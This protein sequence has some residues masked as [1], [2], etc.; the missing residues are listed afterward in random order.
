MKRRRLG[1]QPDED[2]LAPERRDERSELGHRADDRAPPPWLPAR[3]GERRILAQDRLLELLQR[4]AWL[5]PQLVHQQPPPLAVPV[6]RLRLP[7][8]A[9]EGEHQLGARALP[10]RLLRD[11]PLELGDDACVLAQLQ[12]GVD[13]LLERMQTQLGQPAR[14]RLCERLLVKLGERRAAPELERLA[15]E[16]G[17]PSGLSS[18]SGIRL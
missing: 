16:L 11:E 10:Q 12:L 15:Q 14:G 17:A 13:A 1:H 4:R 2:H 8:R 9:I 6:E 5:D 3:L 18:S 7:P